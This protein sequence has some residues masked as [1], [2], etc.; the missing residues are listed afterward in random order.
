MTEQTPPHAPIAL[1][2]AGSD[3]SGGAGIQADL[4]TFAAHGVYGASV[5]TAL[6]AQNTTGVHAIH[7]PPAEFFLQQL[8]ATMED[9]E[10]ASIKTGML[11]NA[12]VIVAL[13]QE[14]EPHEVQHLVVDPVMVSKSG[15]RLLTEDAVEAL[16]ALLLPMA[17]VIT[18]NLPEVEVLL[19][20][21]PMNQ[22]EMA[23]AAWELHELGA[24]AVVV[25]GGHLGS[26]PAHSNDLYF[27]GTTTRILAGPRLDVVHT[28]GTG[29][30]L[31][32]AIAANLALGYP[33]EEAVFRAKDY[34]VGAM[35]AA[36][37]VGRGTGPVN[38]LW[39]LPPPAWHR[40]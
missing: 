28:H 23:Q 10:V 1:T 39:A 32:A 40:A 12:E 38:H 15:H 33:T 19:G 21:R 34:L 27:D 2:I 24:R 31:S 13:A 9:L 17:A 37:P 8:Q 25:K 16:R 5:L 36:Y 7:T 11:S 6:T 22:E 18:P 26:D 30:T 4:K 20:W 35:K 3:S 29:C 14:L